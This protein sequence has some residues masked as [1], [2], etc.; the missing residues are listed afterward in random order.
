MLLLGSFIPKYFILFDGIVSGIISL[1]S[2]SNLLLVV[3]RKAVSCDFAKINY[4][5]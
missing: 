4:E 3:Y 2:L 5:L 1:I